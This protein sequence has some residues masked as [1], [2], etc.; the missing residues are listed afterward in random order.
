VHPQ[1]LG[2]FELGLVFGE[3]AFD[4]DCEIRFCLAAGEHGESGFGGDFDVEFEGDFFDFGDR[5]VFKGSDRV[6]GVALDGAMDVGE[7][8]AH[9][10]GNG[11]LEG[12]S[13]IDGAVAFQIA[14]GGWGCIF[15]QDVVGGGFVFEDEALGHD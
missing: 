14:L 13:G 10:W 15:D 4:F 7:L 2:D 1:I 8:D 6:L 3:F 11:G 12:A 5:E 9:F